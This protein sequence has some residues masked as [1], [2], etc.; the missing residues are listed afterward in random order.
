MNEWDIKNSFSIKNSPSF[1]PAKYFLFTCHFVR[2]RE[3][4]RV[5]EMEV[6]RWIEGDESAAEMLARVSTERPFLLLPPLHRLPL[7]VGNVVELVGPS[8]SAKT[9][10]LTQVIPISTSYIFIYFSLKDLFYT[11]NRSRRCENG[12]FF[13]FIFSFFGDILGRY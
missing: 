1:T 4:E 2:E 11:L 5:G 6:R 7:R 10:I 9:L 8:P 3:S 12:W 13:I